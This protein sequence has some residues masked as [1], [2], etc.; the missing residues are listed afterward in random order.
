MLHLDRFVDDLKDEHKLE[1]GFVLTE[2]MNLVA[3]YSPY[4]TRGARIRSDFAHD[5]F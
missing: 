3:A 4:S 2:N 5:V 1:T